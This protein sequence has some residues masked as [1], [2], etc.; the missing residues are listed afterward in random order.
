[1]LKYTILKGFKDLWTETRVPQGVVEREN[2]P[3]AE[4][5]EIEK[6]QDFSSG[7]KASRDESQIDNFKRD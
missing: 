1:M 7:L 5:P 2:E 3:P 6:N 4:G